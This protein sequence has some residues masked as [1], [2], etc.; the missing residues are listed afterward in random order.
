MDRQI[1][2]ALVLAV[3]VVSAIGGLGTLITYLHNRRKR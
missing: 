1:V 3:C 2:M